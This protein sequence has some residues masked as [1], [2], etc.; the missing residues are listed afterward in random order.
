MA[1]EEVKPRTMPDWLRLAN[2]QWEQ[3]MSFSDLPVVVSEHKTQKVLKPELLNGVV[4]IG[5][6]KYYLETD[7]SVDRFIAYQRW[8]HESAFGVSFKQMIGN[9]RK[10]WDWSQESR[11]GDIVVL[12]YNTMQAIVR[13]DENDIP[14]LK[15][16]ALFLNTENEDTV[17]LDS[18][19][20]DRKIQ[21]WRESGVPIQFFIQLSANLISGFIDD[22][23]A[24]SQA[25]IGK[26]TKKNQST[27]SKKKK[28]NT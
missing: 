8:E 23:N 4:Q 27:G 19:T 16:C 26:E 3:G 24:I 2:S 14:Y 7:L 28:P 22:Y 1:D 12:A 15:L 10:V 18:L 21:H 13:A 6:I 17:A 9:W 11:F 25:T 20:V 5:S